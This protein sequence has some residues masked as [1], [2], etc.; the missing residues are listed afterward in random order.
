MLSV[1]SRFGGLTFARVMR[2]SDDAAPAIGLAIGLGVLAFL[3]FSSMDMLIK[4]LS[5]GYP[6]HQMLFLSALFSLVPVAL[7][8]GGRAASTGSEPA[9][10]SPTPCVAC[11]AW[12][13]P[14]R[15]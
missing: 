3:L 5:A 1:F 4:L 9:G 14:S 6:I 15:R 8:S 7:R 12:Q 10:R 11:L 2:P 13:R